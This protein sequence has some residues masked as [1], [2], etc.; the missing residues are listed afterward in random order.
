MRYKS[1]SLKDLISFISKGIVP[2]YAN[3][4]AENV[5]RL[6]NQRCNRK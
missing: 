1:S 5:I 6:I 4:Y 2:K 3:S